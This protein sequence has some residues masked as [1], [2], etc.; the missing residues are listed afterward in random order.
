MELRRVRCRAGFNAM[1]RSL[2][3]ILSRT[4]LSSFRNSSAASSENST[5]NA[6]HSFL[7]HQAFQR[8]RL[9]GADLTARFE[10][11]GNRLHAQAV[12]QGA[13]DRV[14][15]EFRLRWESLLLRRFCDQLRLLFRQLE[16]D[17]LNEM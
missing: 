17:G 1:V 14:P 15:D 9:P 2:R 12:L 5:R 4:G 7:F 10:D 11:V 16:A 13:G 6:S 8:E 3:A